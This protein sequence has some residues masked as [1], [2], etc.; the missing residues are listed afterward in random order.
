MTSEDPRVYVWVFPASTS[1]PVV[2]GVVSPSKT[3]TG[4]VFQYG[5]SYVQRGGAALGPDLPVERGRIFGPIPGLGMPSTIRDAMPDNWG[6][7]VI[8]RQLGADIE[9][10]LPD[11]RY[12]LESGSDRVGALDF[13]ERSDLYVPRI[14]G[15]TLRA[16]SEAAA[17]IDEDA[18]IGANLLR[19]VRNTL[20]AAG[21]SQPKAY[22]ELDGRSWLAKFTTGYDSISPLIKAERAALYVA[23]K[24]GYDVPQARLVELGGRGLTLLIERF[25]RVGDTRRMVL[26]G[27]TISEYAGASGGSYPDLVDKLRRLS[28][29]PS[30]VGPEL[31]RRLAFRVAMRIDDD[32]L[33]N[34]AVFWDGEHAQF[35]PPFDLSP[36]LMGTPIGLTDIG[37]GSREF[38][39][40]ALVA[41]SRFYQLSRAD[42]VDIAHHMVDTVKT[43]RVDGADIAQMTETEKN[44]L[45]ARTATPGIIGSLSRRTRPAPSGGKRR[46]EVGLDPTP[47]GGNRGSFAA[48]THSPPEVGLQTD[49]RPT[50]P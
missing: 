44:L 9:D 7:Q 34:I 41:R 2:A 31:F 17:A 13:Q 26:S 48:S 33:R 39:L 1:Q 43:H 12:M 10:Q 14:G 42:A 45:I 20:T 37:E 38:T 22:V 3:T 36:D 50:G 47:Q 11:M 4:L 18:P 25:D 32:H 40:E 24:A 19:A 8:N 35:T 21:G 16:V 49:H 29:R 30:E 23:Q 46:G 5:A 15:G 28:E 6:R 27:N